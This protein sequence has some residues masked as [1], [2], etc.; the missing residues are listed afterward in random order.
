MGKTQDKINRRNFLKTVGAAG[1]APAFA[2]MRTAFA[3]E[4]KSCDADAPGKAQKPE[5]PQVPRRKLGKTGV[6]VPVL[7][8][9]GTFNA[10]ENQIILRKSLQ[11]GVNFW[12][13]TDSYEG[14][15]SELGMGKFLAKNPQV[16]KNL[17]LATKATGAKTI[18]DVERCLQASLKRL[19]TRYV[20]L[21]YIMERTSYM[22]HGLSDPAQLTDEL[23]QWVK[24]AKKR[25]LIRFFGFPTHKN[26][27]QCLA[28]AAKLDW[29][30]VIMFIYN[31]RLMQATELQAAIDACHKAGIGLIA[32]KS[33]GRRPDGKFYQVET[34]EDKK[35]VSHF[36][37]RGFT[38]GQAKLKL[39]LEDERFSAACV[40]M[41]N[42]G[43]LT[44]N[45]AAVLDKTKL[46]QT[47]REALKEYA[48]ATCRGYCAGCAHICD[49]ALPDT[50]YVSD[51]MRYLM[52]YNSYGEQDLAK[53]LFAQIPGKVRNKLLSTDYSL[54][55]VRC[56]QRMPIAKL[57]A[58]AVSKLT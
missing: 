42:V 56:P 30:D 45:I 29:I 40:R 38:E 25:G 46:A 13:T 34:E 7:A 23:K 26:M 57:I 43:L 50:P 16:R 48:R 9:G 39:V 54:A 27:A 47:D 44:S 55:E 1:L 15:N 6:E 58:E 52:Y 5:F 18:E 19:N 35:L 24:S 11:W 20:D 51:I 12:D 28:A 36:L 31:F 4:Q 21:Y 33:Q 32:M 3:N 14:G 53:E 22:E 41:V 2:G 37:Q 8:L 49:S 10:I 17:F